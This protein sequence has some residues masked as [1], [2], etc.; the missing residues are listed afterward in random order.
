MQVTRHTALYA[1]FMKWSDVGKAN[2][3]TKV[4]EVDLTNFVSSSYSFFGSKRNVFTELFS[5]KHD[6]GFFLIYFFFFHLS[7]YTSK[8]LR[9]AAPVSDPKG[10]TGYFAQSNI[11]R[12]KKFA[13]LGGDAF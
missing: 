8:Y 3:V 9:I 2:F 4:N 1:L 10:H 5:S 12:K 11:Q 7:C 6:G 13:I